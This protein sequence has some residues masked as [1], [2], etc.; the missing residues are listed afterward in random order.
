MQKEIKNMKKKMNCYVI[1]IWHNGSYVMDK[2]HLIVSDYCPIVYSCGDGLYSVKGYYGSR[3]DDYCS[4]IIDNSFTIQNGSHPMDDDGLI[5]DAVQNAIANVISKTLAIIQM[6]VGSKLNVI[7]DS[8]PLSESMP[9]Q[10]VEI[11]NWIMR[12]IVIDHNATMNNDEYDPS[13]YF[14]NAEMSDMTIFISSCDKFIFTGTAILNE[15]INLSNNITV[16]SNT[17]PYINETIGELDNL[18][19]MI[20]VFKAHLL[21]KIQQ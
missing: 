9:S 10:L 14:V 20:K 16:N 11:N 12:K 15:L 6:E 19:N 7:V 2:Q 13:K 21:E 17:L 1:S 8:V 18:D 4:I 3:T 5:C